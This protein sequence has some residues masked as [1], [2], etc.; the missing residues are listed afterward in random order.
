MKLK[1][2]FLN[3]LNPDTLPMSR[4]QTC[5]EWRGCEESSSPRSS[6]ARSARTTCDQSLLS[7]R[8]GHGSCFS[9]LLPTAWEERWTARYTTKPTSFMILDFSSDIRNW[10][11]VVISYYYGWYDKMCYMIALW[12]FICST[13]FCTGAGV[14]TR[15]C[16][17][18]EYMT[19]A[20]K[21]LAV[22]KNVVWFCRCVFVFV[23]KTMV[24]LL[25]LH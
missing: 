2:F 9:H 8:E 12:A 21:Q 16:H 18:R 14:F 17:H 5:T 10:F 4:L 22:E 6:T 23:T 20:S 11:L 24:P 19:S 25:H 13:V 1:D 3:F 15:L 7:T